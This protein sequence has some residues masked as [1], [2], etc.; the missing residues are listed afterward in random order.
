MYDFPAI[1]KASRRFYRDHD[2][3]T[4]V[5]GV[6]RRPFPAGDVE[7]LLG[8]ANRAGFTEGFAF[9]GFGVQAATLDHLVD[10]CARR[11]APGLSDNHQYA[12]PFLADC[13]AKTP[14][15]K[16][17]QR[18]GDLGARVDGPYVF[19]FTPNPLTNCWGKTGK[20]IA[21]QFHSKSWHG[22]TVMEYL[23]LQRFFAEK[24]GDHRFFEEPQE[25]NAHWLW[26]IDSMNDSDCSVAM[27]TARGIN[28]QA[29][30]I[31]NR[32]SKR[33]AIAGILVPLES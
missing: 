32:E 10:V 25:S 9:P 30:G 17:L 23:V 3:R 22:L 24:F 21:E 8:Q 5:E 19:L 6:P 28:I 4:W 11:H 31:N 27:C 15:G 29:T 18:D 33:G 13:W 20:Q 26:L 2:L 16:L 14:N 7:T 12:E 1:V